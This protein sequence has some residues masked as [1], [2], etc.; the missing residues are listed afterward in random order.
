MQ[1]L[2]LFAYS[3]NPIIECGLFALVASGFSGG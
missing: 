2:R 1:D 3:N